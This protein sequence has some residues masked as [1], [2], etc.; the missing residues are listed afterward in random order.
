VSTP[1]P[2][3]PT[4]ARLDERLDVDVLRYGRVWEDEALLCAALALEPDDDVLSIASAGDN[5][6]ALLATEAR[7]VTAV[8]LSPAQL[9]L[10][11]LH[12]AAI[13]LLDL[14]DH[15]ALVGLAPEG[16]RSRSQL[17]ARVAPQL[18]PASLAWFEHHVG[19]VEAGLVRTGRLDR[20]F[21]TFQEALPELVGDELLDELLH[22]DAAA[23]ASGRA[24]ELSDRL[25]RH[26][27]MTGFFTR[28][29]GRASMERH[30][31][32]PEQLRHVEGE[33]GDVFLARFLDHVAR[34]PTERNPFAWRFLTGDDGPGAAGLALRDPGRRER[35]RGRLDRLRLH[36]GDLAETVDAARRG[37][38]SAVN[39]SDLFEYLDPA[40]TARCFTTLAEGIRPGGR[41]AWW[42]LLVDRD[43]PAELD[44]VL[45][46]P[47]T[48]PE[49]LPADRAWFY[50]SFRL[51]RRTRG[52]VIVGAR[53]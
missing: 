36:R 17:L 47:H 41:V 52:D 7:S 19:A 35:L 6:L 48:D 14:G 15:E 43:A 39:C 28:W 50:G 20:Y 27:E 30:G 32:D 53:R 4:A 44:P 25:R 31:R 16:T 9:A 34:V 5:C 18:E 23:V 21:A 38:W 37:T 40:E 51:R 24:A 2:P 1:T 45:E 29:F 33:V 10:V 49:E 8:D 12:R 11:D 3:A 42:T 22:L 46:R 13:D 26:G